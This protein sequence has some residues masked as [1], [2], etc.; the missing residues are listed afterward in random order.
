MIASA[1]QL[2]ALAA[3]TATGGLAGVAMDE[4]HGRVKVILMHSATG[5]AGETVDVK[6]QHRNGT[7]AWEDIPGAAF[8]QLTNAAG[9]SQMI[10][11]DADG[12][13]DEVRLHCTCSADA[14]ATLAAVVVGRKQYG[15]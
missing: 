6:L 12:F 5:G 8:E 7:D 4:F 1:K 15:G 3:V 9:C 2:A 11:V 14:D 10:E 13:K